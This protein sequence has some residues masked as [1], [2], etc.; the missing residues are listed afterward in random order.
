M[1]S[2]SQLVSDKATA[3]I[4]VRG[5]TVEVSYNPNKITMRKMAELTR[6]ASAD[7]V[8][9]IADMIPEILDS[10]DLEGPLADEDGNELVAAGDVIPVDPD[11]LVEL[12]AMFLVEL[13]HKMQELAMSG[14]NPTKVTPR[15][16]K[17]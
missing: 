9:A 11:L 10:W 15:S 5:L 14:P 17:R 8:E 12:P 1:P 4:D 7:D 3:N 13:S 2:I 6:R 16:R